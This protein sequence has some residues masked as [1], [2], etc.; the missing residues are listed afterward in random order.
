MRTSVINFEAKLPIHF[1]PI[2]R[3]SKKY[4]MTKPMGTLGKNEYGGRM[5]ILKQNLPPCKLLVYE[6]DILCPSCSELKE[7][8]TF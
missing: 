6:K 2:S 5:S 1:K 8:L 3:I 7:T 4:L